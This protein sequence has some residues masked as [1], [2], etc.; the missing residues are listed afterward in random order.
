MAGMRAAVAALRGAL[1]SQRSTPPHTTSSLGNHHLFIMGSQDAAPKTPQDTLS[2]YFDDST[3]AV[4]QKFTQYAH[5]PT[6]NTFMQPNIMPASKKI[7]FF[8]L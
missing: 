4:R 8:P 7:T 3:A 6:C 1:R 5:Q 2:S